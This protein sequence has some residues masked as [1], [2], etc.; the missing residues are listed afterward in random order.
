MASLECLFLEEPDLVFGYEGEDK[1]PRMG[2]KRFGPYFS[3]SEGV[4]SPS[5]VRVGIVGSGETIT[6]TK[7]LLSMIQREIK[8]NESNRWLYP[9]F[10]GFSSNTKLKSEIL[11][12]DRWNISL[13]QFEIDG[14]LKVI[15]ANER[16]AAAS[17]LIVEKL[18][19][20]AL[21]ED[22][23]NVVICSLPWVIEEYCGISKRTRGAKRPR[24]TEL[25]RVLSEL[26]GKNQSFLQD[27][28]F[29]FAEEG[30]EPNIDYDLHNSIKGK[31]MSVGIPT[32][33]LRESTLKSI[34]EYPNSTF[35]SRQNPATFAW[36]FSMG[37]Y[38]KAN[39]RPWRLA[40]LVPG[41]CYVGVSFYR[42]L[43]NPNLNVESSMAQ[44]F[45]HSGEGFVLRGT[46]VVIDEES[47]EPRLTADQSEHLIRDVIDKYTAKVH[48]GPSRFVVHKTSRFNEEEKTG[49]RKG[50]GT[51][52]TDLVAISR[53]TPIRF[54]RT[55][56][57]PVLRGTLILITSKEYLLYTGG[58]I[59]RIRTYPGHRVPE[60][61]HIVHEG[62]S[63]ART[64][65]NEILGL[66]KLNWNTTAFSTY[67]PI[68]LE[69][70]DRVGKIL[71]E[72][73]EDSPTQDHYRFYM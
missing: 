5:Q 69:F 58:Y 65:C 47:K 60:P 61:L 9:D 35:P 33:V 38:Y 30:S 59:P 6:L 10:P 26:R 20:I 49:L 68:T 40:K 1:D 14:I 63:D 55:G 53:S 34:L 24:F 27:W 52:P 54:L 46:D 2:I 4:P 29:D 18:K 73:P 62:D 71:S 36:N 50:I 8:S 31:S 21:E 41:T 22:H 19:A 64:V 7:Q 37:L 23:P 67:N 72:L 17:Q 51:I 13:T 15:D 16:I 42:N 32:Q 39:G 11:N 43:R 66:T 48:T 12:A 25:E 3:R 57:Y 70:A 45:T 56:E 28:G 44:I